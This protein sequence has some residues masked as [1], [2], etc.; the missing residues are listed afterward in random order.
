MGNT[1]SRHVSK[2]RG[3]ID[4][5]SHKPGTRY[6]LS[7]DKPFR[8]QDMINRRLCNRCFKV[9]DDSV[10]GWPSMNV[11]L[12]LKEKK[13]IRKLKLRDGATFNPWWEYE[14]DND[15]PSIDLLVG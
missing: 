5:P 8:S 9:A 2:L 3:D 10:A 15:I 13:A 6:C 1:R 4:L 12:T 14:T 7:C 11:V